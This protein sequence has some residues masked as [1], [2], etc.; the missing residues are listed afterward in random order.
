MK[1]IMKPEYYDKFR[2]IADECSF[3]CCQEWNI[4]VD[5]DT[6]HRW[7]NYTFD[8]KKLNS[9]TKLKEGMHA[10]RLN[11]AHKCP[12][13]TDNKLCS[14]VVKHGD[15]ILSNTCQS[16]PR[17]IHEYKDRTEASVT[18]CCPA[19][20]DLMNEQDR[21]RLIESDGEHM[22]LLENNSQMPEVNNEDQEQAVP[23]AFLSGK[24]S[25]KE[26]R[27][28]MMDMI[29]NPVL[30]INMELMIL[31]DMM[32]EI[33][34]SRSV[35]RQELSICASDEHMTGVAAE[36]RKMNFSEE[37]TFAEDNELF[38]DLIENYRK[39][40]LYTRF[41]G[42]LAE[43]AEHL[44]EGYEDYKVQEKLTQF[45]PEFAKYEKLFRNYLAAEFFTNALLP[46]CN[47]ESLVVMMQW[48]S[49]EYVAIRHAIFLTWMTNGSDEIAYT[50][51]R[52][53]IVLISR[54]TGYDQK[55][56]Y[57]YLDHSFQTRIWEW[58]YQALIIGNG[59]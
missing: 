14:L 33:F 16:F 15:Q 5:K 4:A 37:D 27:D 1:K 34:D 51:V 39:E 38:L 52:D 18:S 30:D 42:P 28:T 59:K 49:M 58:G 47:M 2:C 6:H 7:Q 19:V 48:I 20:I 26:I 32:L 17:Q 9:Y 8:G 3:T 23:S 24:A 50:D 46:D 45:K 57:E 10:I 11:E 40:G 44:E 54:I 56:I 35:T 55:D 13:L 22:I 43:L 31:F 21:I 12:F 25:L 36:I 29:Q 53:C 41:L